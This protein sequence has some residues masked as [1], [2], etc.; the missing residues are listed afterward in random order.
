MRPTNKDVRDFYFNKLAYPKITNAYMKTGYG[1][2]SRGYISLAMDF[3]SKNN[4][5]RHI[6]TEIVHEELYYAL[7]DN[8]ENKSLSYLINVS[9]I[10]TFD[11]DSFNVLEA[12]PN[13]KWHLYVSLFGLKSIKDSEFWNKSFKKYPCLQLRLWMAETAC[14]NEEYVEHI[15]SMIQNK[16]SKKEINAAIKALDWECI[17]EKISQSK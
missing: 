8:L 5:E 12:E 11:I 15:Y 9:D 3:V 13:Q 4:N 6:F 10:K 14:V 1:Q 2:R 16:C 17:F 7:K